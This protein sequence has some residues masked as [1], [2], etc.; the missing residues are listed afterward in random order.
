V[1]IKNQMGPARA[2]ATRPAR[3]YP[4]DLS[5]ARWRL[6]AACDGFRC[7]TRRDLVDLGEFR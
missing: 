4:S 5:D 3:G 6:I 1:K 2:Q 7:H